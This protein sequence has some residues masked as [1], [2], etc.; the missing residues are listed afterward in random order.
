MYLN[1]PGDNKRLGKMRF[2]KEMDEYEAAQILGFE[3][4]PT[5]KNQVKEYHRKMM[6]LNHPDSGGSNFLA[7]KINEARDFLNQKV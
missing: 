7:T 3:K 2:R 5:E 4:F 6:Q 1:V